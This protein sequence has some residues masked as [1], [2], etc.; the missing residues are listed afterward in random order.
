M[1][2][3]AFIREDRANVAVELHLS[4]GGGQI[5]EAQAA[6]KNGGG[7][8]TKIHRLNIRR[9]PVPYSTSSVSD[10]DG[11]NSATSID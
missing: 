1:T 2:V 4:C 7:R 9:Y 5:G 8:Q 10:R 11:V 3:K 6:E